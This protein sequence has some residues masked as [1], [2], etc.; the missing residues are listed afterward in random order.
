MYIGP[1]EGMPQGS[2]LQ[3]RLRSSYIDA[4]EHP[5]V[6]RPP[7]FVPI[8]KMDVAVKRGVTAISIS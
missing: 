8:R 7:H 4:F 1:L 3:G 2:F 6:S 5:V